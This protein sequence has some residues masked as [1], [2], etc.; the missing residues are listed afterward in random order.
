MRAKPPG[1]TC[2]PSRGAGGEDA[3]RHRRGTSS[4]WMKAGVV[5][6]VTAS[7]PTSFSPSLSSHSAW[8][9]RWRVSAIPSRARTAVASARRQGHRGIGRADDHALEP[10]DHV[11]ALARLAAPPGGDFGRIRSSPSSLATERS[12][13]RPSGRG[14]RR[15][16][17]PSALT[18]LTTEPAAGPRRCRACR[19]A[20]SSCVELQRVGERRRR[21]AARARPTGLSP[22]T[23]RTMTLPS[24]DRQVL[25]FEQ[26]EAEIAGDIGV[27]EIGFVE[28]GPA[29]DRRC[30]RLD[31]RL[32]PVISRQRARKAPEEAGEPLDI[33]F[34]K[35]SEK[36]RAV[37]TR[38]SSAKPAPDGA[39]V[40]SE[41]TH[42]RPSGPRPRSKAQDAGSVPAGLHADQRAQEF[43]GVAGDQ[44]P[45]SR[46]FRDQGIVSP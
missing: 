16:R 33:H 23:V 30:G 15:R 17:Q 18:M 43:A 39:C 25:A 4:P 6:S 3:Q 34:G 40:R 29:S 38:F 42:Q 32:L 26:H 31:L 7:W 28:R 35:T 2:Q 9:T 24:I 1:M 36:A 22:A 5:E 14:F 41:S 10:F 20:P 37:A 11:L 27:L 46:P 19:Y 12:A 13:G 8:P 45:G 44:R 21:C